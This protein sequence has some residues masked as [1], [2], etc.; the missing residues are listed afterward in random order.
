MSDPGQRQQ[1]MLVSEIFGPTLQGEGAHIG[2][3]SAFVRLGGCNLACSWCDTWYAWDWQR[4][5][6]ETETKTMPVRDVGVLVQALQ[7][8]DVV[9]TGGEPMLQARAVRSLVNDYLRP[10]SMRTEMETAGTLLPPDPNL[11]DL[12]T[13]SPKLHGSGNSLEKRRKPG[14]LDWFARAPLGR[15]V[16]K[17]VVSKASPAEDMREIDGLVAQF[18]IAPPVVYIMPEGIDTADIDQGLRTVAQYAIDRGYNVTT[19][20]HVQIWGNVRGV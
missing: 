4:A 11:V 7:C 15:A 9:I 10:H 16:F 18:G 20:L 5:N 14:A 3:P 17:F 1:H 19:R 8:K 13:V 2:R 12:F 6:I